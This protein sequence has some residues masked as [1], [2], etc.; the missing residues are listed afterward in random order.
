MVLLNHA[1][2]GLLLQAARVFLAATHQKSR[3]TFYECGI[4]FEGSCLIVALYL[5]T[6]PAKSV[7]EEKMT[8]F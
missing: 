6:F 5:F 3:Q 8:I 1:S 7:F 2:P 4:L